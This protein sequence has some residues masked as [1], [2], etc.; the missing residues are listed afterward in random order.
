MDDLITDVDEV[1]FFIQL[2]AQRSILIQDD[3]AFTRAFP[4]DFH[5]ISLISLR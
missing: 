5:G 2:I 4:Y 1:A 3:V